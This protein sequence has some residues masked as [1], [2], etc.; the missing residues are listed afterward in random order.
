MEEL[1][2]Y[3]NV[4]LS[5]AEIDKIL[6]VLDEQEVSEWAIGDL[7]SGYTKLVERRDQIQAKKFSY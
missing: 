7:E 4:T 6:D 1:E 3:Y 2:E 5:L